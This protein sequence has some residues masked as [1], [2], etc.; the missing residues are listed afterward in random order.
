[1][2]LPWLL[3]LSIF[4]ATPDAGGST[5]MESFH[6]NDFF[7]SKLTAPSSIEAYAVVQQTLLL[8]FADSK[9][10]LPSHRNFQGGS[11]CSGIPDSMA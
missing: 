6:H 5:T 10:S 4:S 2:G 11:S 7:A 1:M 3:H 9:E 8:C